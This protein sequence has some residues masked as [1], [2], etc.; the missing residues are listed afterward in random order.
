MFTFKS[1]FTFF[2]NSIVYSTHQYLVVLAKDSHIQIWETEDLCG[3]APRFP[4][5]TYK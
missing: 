5:I 2:Y 1:N 4:Q 3:N